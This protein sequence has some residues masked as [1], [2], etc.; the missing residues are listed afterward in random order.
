MSGEKDWR[1]GREWERVWIYASDI[2]HQLDRA[3]NSGS[4]D[5]QFYVT[6]AYRHTLDLIEYVAGFRDGN[7]NRVRN[8]D[9]TAAEGDTAGNVKKACAPGCCEHNKKEDEHDH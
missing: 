6:S 1:G 9:G 2:L 3:T 7:G 4:G 8:G 5:R